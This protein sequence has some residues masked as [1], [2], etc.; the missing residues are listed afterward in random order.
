MEHRTPKVLEKKPVIAGLDLLSVVVI[1][2]CAILF[3]F[4]IFTVPLVSIL[5]LGLTIGY[6]YINKKYP[7]K[8]QLAAVLKFNFGVKCYRA[9]RPLRS[10]IKQR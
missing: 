1:A 7:K 4:T 3:L 8:G 10:F 9:Q 6:V 5:F 2:I